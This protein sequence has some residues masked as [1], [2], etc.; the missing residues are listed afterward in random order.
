MTLTNGTLT[1]TG[2]TGLTVS[3]NGSTTNPLVLSGTT[4]LINAA[5]A[6]LV[7]TPTGPGGSDTLALLDTDT[8]DNLVSSVSTV[9]IAFG[10]TIQAPT[11]VSISQGG[12]FAFAGT[13]NTNTIALADSIAAMAH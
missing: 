11:S 12:S 1:V 7:Y 13:N 5:L 3:G 6:T 8:A 9:S 10:P 4:S 2:Q